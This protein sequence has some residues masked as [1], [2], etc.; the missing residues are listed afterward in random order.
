[1][2]QNKIKEKNITKKNESSEKTIVFRKIN[3]FKK[4]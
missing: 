4:M 3:P 2:I 1:M